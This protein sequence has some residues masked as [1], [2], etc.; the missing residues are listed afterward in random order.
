[1]D[2]GIFF[3]YSLSSKAYRVYNEQ[4]RK[5]E[6]YINV[7][8]DETNH[9]IEEGDSVGEEVETEPEEMFGETTFSAPQNKDETT[10]K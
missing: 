6:E 5:A 4:T 1:M 3:E 10:F 8:F 9:M 2:K 7:K